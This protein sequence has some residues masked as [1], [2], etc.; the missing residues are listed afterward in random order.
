MLGAVAIGS[1]A[2]LVLLV[3]AIACRQAGPSIL[4]AAS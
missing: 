4:A 1:F 2:S 3:S